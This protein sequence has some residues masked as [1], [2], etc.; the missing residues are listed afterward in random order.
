MIL[1][2]CGPNREVRRIL[3]VMKLIPL[4]NSKEKVYN[5]ETSL[6]EEFVMRNSRKKIVRERKHPHTK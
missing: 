5:S 2:W 4:R 3:N 1:I 6:S